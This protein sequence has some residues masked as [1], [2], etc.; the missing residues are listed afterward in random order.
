M[1]KTTK[2]LDILPNCA[3]SESHKVLMDF[4]FCKTWFS[5]TDKD[6]WFVSSSQVIGNIK[7]KYLI[8]IQML[9]HIFTKMMSTASHTIEHN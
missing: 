2:K 8:D 1:K 4:F 7:E 9:N 5:F 3:C 6:F